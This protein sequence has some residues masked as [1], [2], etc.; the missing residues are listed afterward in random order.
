MPHIC[1]TSAAVQFE[2]LNP[3][4][5]LD[6]ADETN[7]SHATAQ[8]LSRRVPADALQVVQARRPSDRDARDV[9]ASVLKQAL[10]YKLSM[11]EMT[12]ALAHSTAQAAP[13]TTV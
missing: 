10:P 2:F 1:K 5:G 9:T 3:T 4:F 12:V 13:L 6:V 8:S 11:D 7:A